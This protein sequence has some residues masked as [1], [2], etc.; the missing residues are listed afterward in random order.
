M[1]IA[2]SSNSEWWV[3][4]KGHHYEGMFSV[5]SAYICSRTM[6]NR[7]GKVEFSRNAWIGAD[8][9]VFASWDP[10]KQYRFI[11]QEG[12]VQGVHEVTQRL[13][14]RPESHA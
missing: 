11:M 1:G 4:D 8:T 9:I 7:W 13:N 5:Q 2:C 10:E 12:H 14:V 3:V 6:K